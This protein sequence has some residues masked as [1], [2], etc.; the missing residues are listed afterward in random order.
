MKKSTLNFLAG[1][2]FLFV[3]V[4]AFFYLWYQTE[5]KKTTITYTANYTPVEI[6]GLK[7]QAEK[8]VSSFEN[9]GGLPI[10]I[11]KEKMGKPNPFIAAE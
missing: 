2:A 8:I 10:P 6:T 9:N 1:F 4:G 5:Q 7:A 3:T 11:P